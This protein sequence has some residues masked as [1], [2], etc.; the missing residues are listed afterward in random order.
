[1]LKISNESV[2]RVLNKWV[3]RQINRTAIGTL[4]PSKSEMSD[5]LRSKFS[6]LCNQL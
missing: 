1:M 6:R 4:S 2:V 3:D 5:N